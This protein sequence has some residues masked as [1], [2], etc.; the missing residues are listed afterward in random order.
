M[1]TKKELAQKIADAVDCTAKV[2]VKEDKVRVYLSHRGKDYGFVAVTAKGAEFSLTGYGNN[3]YKRLIREAI[4]GIEISEPQEIASGIRRLTLQEADQLASS[5][6]PKSDNTNT[7]HALNAMYGK[8]GW[9][10][11]DREDYEG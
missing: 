11:W 6:Q 7:E 5:R 10:R 8:G 4:E 1:A 9:D 3:T 2:W